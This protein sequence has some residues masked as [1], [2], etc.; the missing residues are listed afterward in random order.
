MNSNL[1]AE[2]TLNGSL[3]SI[4]ASLKALVDSFWIYSATCS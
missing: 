2:T 4:V 3:E 1:L